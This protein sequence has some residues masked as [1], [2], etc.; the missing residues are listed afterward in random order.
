[1]DIRI[2]KMLAI[3]LGLT[4]IAS[5]AM[6]L[7]H[8]AAEPWASPS[9]PSV[10]LGVELHLHPGSHYLGMRVVPARDMPPDPVILQVPLYPGSTTTHRAI[11]PPTV[12][13][14]YL[15]TD[16]KSKVAEYV[17]PA[18]VTRVRAWYWRTFTQCGF[19]SQ[20]EISRS[21]QH[22]HKTW[23]R[24]FDSPSLAQAFVTLTYEGLEPSSTLVQYH[25]IAVT[26]PPR[27]ASSGAPFGAKSVQITYYSPYAKSINNAPTPIRLTVTQH[28][29]IE[30]LN[31]ALESPSLTNATDQLLPMC[32][33]GVSPPDLLRFA[34]P[35]GKSQ[36]FTVDSSCPW[37]IWIEHTRLNDPGSSV[38]NAIG[39][40]V[41]QWLYAHRS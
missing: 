26:T 29:S 24:D 28:A 32:P 4:A 19:A 20:S 2:T 16:I 21:D 18:A 36:V 25:A 11:E 22:G 1:M 37:E 8:A 5:G 30:T 41:Y 31:L 40:V 17:V 14:Y 39:F 12:G 23:A 15:G 27:P 35:N 38:A 3:G 6:V 10:C 33:A 7:S 34:L 9:A 13:Q